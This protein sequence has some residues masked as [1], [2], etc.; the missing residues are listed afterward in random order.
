MKSMELL[1]IGSSMLEHQEK[2]IAILPAE[3]V[4]KIFS[5]NCLGNREQLAI[6]L[7]CNLW[8]AFSSNN[9][10]WQVLFS[11][12]FSWSPGL[13]YTNPSIKE[14]YRQQLALNISFEEKCKPNHK[15]FTKPRLLEAI[16]EHN[17][18]Q[19]SALLHSG[20][21]IFVNADQTLDKV[22]D[23]FL[24]VLSETTY[25]P[26]GLMGKIFENG[27]VNENMER[28]GIDAFHILCLKGNPTLLE[29]IFTLLGDDLLKISS[30][31]DRDGVDLFSHLLDYPFYGSPEEIYA[32]VQTG[33]EKN[34][35]DLLLET[36]HT[37][38]GKTKMR[39]LLTASF[40]LSIPGRHDSFIHS[41]TKNIKC[42]D[43]NYHFF[44]VFSYLEKEDYW[45]LLKEG[46]NNADIPILHLLDCPKSFKQLIMILGDD[47]PELLRHENSFGYNFLYTILI[48]QKFSH[49]HLLEAAMGL[50]FMD[51][52]VKDNHTD[53]I[54][55][56]M[57]NTQVSFI[58][59]G[60]IQTL[61]LMK[62]YNCMDIMQK[63][64]ENPKFSQILSENYCLKKHDIT[65]I[66]D[67]FKEYLEEETFDCILV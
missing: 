66:S 16:R 39:S 62:K 60:I 46:S 21:G 67:T 31:C 8:A 23:E 57:L 61:R 49:I 58:K 43:G 22:F 13:F 34:R 35:L 17:L 7:V 36:F 40:I 18:P 14:S 65:E 30:F 12:K 10:I 55:K 53:N 45:I 56:K 3:L 5:D 6:S 50:E 64:Y 11:K 54:L 28:Y 1:S 47:A 37:V 20:H 2:I 44:R 26:S 51:L 42:P 33:E 27:L 38:L 19:V 59:E 63:T 48:Q 29:K 9:S 15:C 52:L 41:L 4:L 25:L 24:L 32:D